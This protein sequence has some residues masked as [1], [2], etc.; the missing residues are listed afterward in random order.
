MDQLQPKTV[1]QLLLDWRNGERA[2]LDELLTLAYREIHK[3]ARNMVKNERPGHLLQA[4]ALINEVFLKL[5]DES[6]VDWKSRDDFFAVCAN[7]MGEILV[8][9]R[10]AENAL[11]RGGGYQFVSLNEAPEVPQSR[12][13]ELS[14]LDDALKELGR[15]S[16]RQRQVVQ[17]RFFEGLSIDET[18]GKLC[19]S[20]ETIKKDWRQA[21]AYLLRE[22]SRGETYDA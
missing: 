6:Q 12:R 2:A 20:P 4:T 7:L 9:I 5:V 15:L 1:T 21:R 10:R 14:A 16:S 22:L 19:L 18:A 3:R 8:D 11:K 13:A 17:L